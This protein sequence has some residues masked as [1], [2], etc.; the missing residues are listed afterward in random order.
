MNKILLVENE[1]TGKYY[2]SLLEK[3]ID[4]LEIK[5][6]K[7]KNEVF[8][9]CNREENI[10]VIVF[11]QRLDNGE[12]GI[13]IIS[14]LKRNR[15][16]IL[17]IMLS[18]YALPNDATNAIKEGII[19]EYVNKNDIDMLPAK[20]VDALRYYD[21]KR[22]L[23][24]KQNRQY[25][26]KIY[27][28]NKILIHPLKLY[29]TSKVL[30]DDNYVFEDR[31]EELYIINAGEEQ[32][33]KKSIEISTSVKIENG[34][35]VNSSFGV[36]M[37][38]IKELIGG[39]F[40]SEIELSEKET[41]ELCMKEINEVVRT[42]RMPAIPQSVDEDYLTTTIFE[43]AQIFKKYQLIVEQECLSCG[44]SIY[45]SFNVF[46]PTN[47]KCL[48]KINTYKSGKQENIEVSLKK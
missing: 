19:F 11:D 16:D 48:R 15:P 28:R 41:K 24:S 29:I 5:W 2:K 21:V 25:I 34:L 39:S 45:Y 35:S 31:W 7:S 27:K 40:N 44:E 36:E 38:K 46:V 47:G 13:R 20:V 10:K 4:N 8:D 23:D 3:S 37:E 17:G 43:G 12:L 33:H 26:G 1:E 42:Y 32:C 18:A 9:F 30:V 6:V 14:E 22:M